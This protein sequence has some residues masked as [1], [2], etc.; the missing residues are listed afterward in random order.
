MY[1]LSNKEPHILQAFLNKKYDENLY[2]EIVNLS[3]IH[4]LT[5]KYKSVQQ[6]SFLEY[7]LNKEQI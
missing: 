1:S 3:N 4:K 6:K 7:I 2:N 5:Y